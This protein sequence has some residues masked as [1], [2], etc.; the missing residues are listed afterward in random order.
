MANTVSKPKT[1]TVA[2]G[3]KRFTKGGKKLACIRYYVS[4]SADSSSTPNPQRPAESPRGARSRKRNLPKSTLDQSSLLG[5]EPIPS[6]LLDQEILRVMR[7]E[8]GDAVNTHQRLVETSTLHPRNTS[9]DVF[10]R[11]Q[12]LMGSA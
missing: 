10:Q 5:G 2:R 11:Y 7:E 8:N 1:S 4:P 9:A 6:S 3:L 12:D